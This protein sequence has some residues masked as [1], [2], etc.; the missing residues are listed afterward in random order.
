MQEVCHF[1]IIIDNSQII[2]G[3]GHFECIITVTHITWHTRS[4]FF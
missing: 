1:L 2:V 4:L 3:V